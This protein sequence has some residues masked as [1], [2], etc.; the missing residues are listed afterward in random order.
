VSDPFSLKGKRAFVT[1]ANTGI[2]QGIAVALA[3][4]GAQ[5]LAAGRSSMAETAK[6]IDAVGGVSHEIRID[7]EKPAAAAKVLEAAWA[8]QG[9]IDILANNAGITRRGDAIDITEADWDVVMDVN[10]KAIFLLS[11]AF[12]RRV[13]AE[14]RKARIVMT[15]SMMS[16]QGGIRIAPYT[17]SKAG[18]AGLT[19]ILANEWAPRGIN[20]NAIA[21]GYIETNNTKPL[22]ADPVRYQEILKRIP[23]GHWGKPEDIGG[24]AVFLS[25]DAASYVHGAMLNVDGGWLAR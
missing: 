15:A 14:G 9:P 16:F 22:L 17:A 13:F 4:A 12:A 1:G 25:S 23:A 6:L 3:R 19:R 5:V 10:L 7:L 11:Q 18:L 20:V 24:M 21:P 8:E 2:G